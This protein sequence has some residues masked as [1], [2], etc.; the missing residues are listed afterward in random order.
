[1]KM[2]WVGLAFGL[3]G[4][5]LLS[6]A[7]GA[8]DLSLG[9]RHEV[10]HPG[11]AHEVHVSGAAV[12]AAPDGPLVA[13]AAQEGEVNQLYVARLGDGEPRPMRV[14]PP[15]L[16]VEALH[17][18]PRLVVATSGEVYLSWS[19]AKPKPEGTLFAS[20]L[21]LSR[22]LD[23]GR[24]FAGHVRVNEDRPISHSFD[25]LAVAPDGTVLV[26][27]I[28]GREGRRDPSTYLARVVE[29]GTRVDS[30]IKVADETCVCCRVDAAAGP[31]GQVAL[32]WRRVFPGD[33]RDM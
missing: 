10:R 24:T 2:G 12:V 28:D 17:H 21:R 26:T 4:L 30:V 5:I 22:S 18:P 31:G 15:D 32:L 19:S 25:G 13:W 6:A 14:N 33:I 1:M 3:I 9:P 27:W 20:D 23:S 11:K 16:T 7:A 29:R 8:A